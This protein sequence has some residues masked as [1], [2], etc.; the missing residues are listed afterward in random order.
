MNGGPGSG[1]SGA[2]VG[3]GG[4]GG[5]FDGGCAAAAIAGGGGG[6]SSAVNNT[7]SGA[8]GGGGGGGS[9][10]ATPTGTG[11]S[12]ALS[13]M[14]TANH[15]GQVIISY[16]VPSLTIT[17]THTRHFTQGRDGTYAITVGNAAGAAPTNVTTVTVHDTLPA[18]SNYLPI[19]LKVDVSC[20]AYAQVANTATATGGGDTTTRTATDLTKIKRHNHDKR[21]ERH[22]HW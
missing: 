14:G 17:K 18:G 10:F 9:S 13:A 11:T 1:F 5:N 4:S 6:G 12:Y 19:T 3:T 21:C 22:D 20:R 15:N 16:T 7:G 8:G 2:T